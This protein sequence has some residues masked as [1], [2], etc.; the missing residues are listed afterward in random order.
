M[1]SFLFFSSDASGS[2]VI[3]PIFMS[4]MHGLLNFLAISSISRNFTEKQLFQIH[5]Y[6]F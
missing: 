4:L 6:V 1:D 5:S 2:Y 3:G